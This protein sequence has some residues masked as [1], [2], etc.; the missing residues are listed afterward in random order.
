MARRLDLAGPARPTVLSEAQPP[1][2][3]KVAARTKG[4]VTLNKTK[5]RVRNWAMDPFRVTRR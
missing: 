1:E 5:Y 3:T 4:K 2:T